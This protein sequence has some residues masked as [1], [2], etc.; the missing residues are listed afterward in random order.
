MAINISNTLWL[1]KRQMRDNAASYLYSAIYFVFMGL[2]LAPDRNWGTEVAFPILMLIIIQP[3]LSAKYMTFKKDN[4][5]V[6]HQIFLHSLP[7][8]FNNIIAARVIG[9]LAAGLINVPVF[10]VP[11]WIFAEGW[12]SV[13][14]FIAWVLFWVGL[15]LAGAGLA[16]YQE[17][18]MTL[19]SW[20]RL[21][22]VA[23]LAFTGLL[24]LILQ[25]LDT[26]PVQRTIELS[27]SNPWILA[28]TGLAFGTGVLVWMSGRAVVGLRRREFAA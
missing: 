20:T 14:N 21:N 25:L 8:G 9:M 24:I 7:V 6:R 2:V 26:Y 13:T 15:A 18:R 4:E 10:F 16:L 1:A 28:G 23:V 3:S 22:F 12:D 27:N 19:A 17:F 11:F 5:V